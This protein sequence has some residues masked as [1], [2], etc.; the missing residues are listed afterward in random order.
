MNV[1]IIKPRSGHSQ[2]LCN[3]LVNTAL[4]FL[5]RG[6]N[7]GKTTPFTQ[8]YVFITP[9][10][11]C[12]QVWSEGLNTELYIFVYNR[13]N[14]IFVRLWPYLEVQLSSQIVMANKNMEGQYLFTNETIEYSYLEVQFVWQIIMADNTLCSSS[15][16][17]RVHKIAKRVGTGLSVLCVAY[18]THS[19]LKPVPTLLP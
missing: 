17:R 13:N 19:T 11:G 3:T 8:S 14:R 18:A 6:R 16:F 4:I 10:W 1:L 9:V 5:N 15:V 7:V 2:T 12:W